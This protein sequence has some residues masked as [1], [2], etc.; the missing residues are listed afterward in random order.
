[1]VI[2]AVSRRRV[3][4]LV[5]FLMLVSISC[6][7][8]ATSTPPVS[9]EDLQ[10]AEPPEFTLDQGK[11]YLATL[12]TEKG[13][14]KIELFADRAPITVN[15]FV[16]LAEQGYYNGTTFHRVLPDFMAQGGD[17]T[18]TGGGGPGYRFEDEIDF[19]TFFDEAG[20]FAMAN[21]GPDTNGS[22]F[23]ITFGP[24][25]YL[26]GNHTIFG[27]VVEGMDVVL[28]LTLRNPQESPEF[29]GDELKSVDIE[30][31]PESLLPPPE[32]T[33]IPNPPE[34]ADGRPLASLPIEERANL[35]SGKPAMVID[36]SLT[37]QAVVETTQGEFVIQMDSATAPESVNNFV[38]L[39]ELGFFDGF[40]L[41]AVY[42]GELALFGSPEGN[43]ASDIGYGLLVESES[44]HLRG[45]VGF[46]FRQD[47]LRLS[48]SQIYILLSDT[49]GL[50]WFFTVFGEVVEGMEV[51]DALTVDDTIVEITIQNE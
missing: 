6:T 4:G 40:P 49:P 35:Y 19:D 20:Y 38:V 44:D 50:S 34:P 31:I 37:Y 11:I 17:P 30:V 25:M 27:K 13:D 36:P 21:G 14:I 41:N 2:S 3:L 22:Q 26:N 45:S 10:W 32:P 5:L 51:V 29:E 18:G 7:S 23:F 46:W 39:A 15:N 8:S 24:T 47:I 12:E 33:P 43:P 42:P 1:M 9:S 16:F 48:G 28:S